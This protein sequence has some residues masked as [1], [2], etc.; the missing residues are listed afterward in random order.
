MPCNVFFR[1][2][3]LGFPFWLSEQELTSR[4][5]FWPVSLLCSFF[6]AQLPS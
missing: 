3:E 1:Y 5:S 4:V 2:T 6:S